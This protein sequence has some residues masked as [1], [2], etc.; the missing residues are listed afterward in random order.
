MREAKEV[1]RLYPRILGDEALFQMGLIYAYPRNPDQDYQ[2]SLKRFQRVIKEFPKSEL[3][4]Q[5]EVWA[6]VLQK[7]I[8]KDRELGKLEQRN[9]YLGKA[10]EK[11]QKKVKGLESQV[12]KLKDQVEKLKDQVEKLKDQLLRLKEIDL[13]IEEKKSQAK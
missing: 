9:S 2:K 1:L 7:I 8:D 6:C 4:D 5:A 3:K 11:K 10:L 13:G 12:E